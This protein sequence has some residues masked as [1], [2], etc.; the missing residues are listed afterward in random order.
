MNDRIAMG[1]YQA[2]TEL[3]L[4]VPQDISM[5]SFDDSD[6]ARW[7]RPQ[8]TSVA[9]PHFEMGRRAVELL[10][11]PE[12]PTIIERVP[13]PLRVRDSVAAPAR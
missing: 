10:L 3:G 6:L 13:M 1:A 7:L 12:R 4:S 5:V 9:I 11:T 8:L 2:C